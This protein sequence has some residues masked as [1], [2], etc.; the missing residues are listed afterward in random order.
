MDILS[1]LTKRVGDNTMKWMLTN[2]SG[3]KD[4]ALTFACI[5]LAIAAV[6]VF[7]STLESIVVGSTTV[8]FDK[9]DTTLV[10]GI[11]SATL[12]AYVLRANKRQNVELEHKKLEK[13]SETGEG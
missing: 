12:G 8:S 4:A 7:A 11:L 1:F 2:S 6:S 9:P 10:L 5:G 13:S 3:K